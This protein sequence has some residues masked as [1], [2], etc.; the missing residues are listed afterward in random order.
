MN[1]S[2]GKRPLWFWLLVYAAVGAVAYF[3]IYLAFLSG[4][5]GGGSL[6]Y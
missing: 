3:L 5:G 2:Y 1:K 6:G 4:G